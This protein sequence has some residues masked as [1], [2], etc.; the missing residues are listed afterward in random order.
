MNS[1]MLCEKEFDGDGSLCHDCM[2]VVRW[3]ACE[4]CGREFTTVETD[5]NAV[6]DSCIFCG[7]NAEQEK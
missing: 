6:L 7:R 2:G 3:V 5:Y 4:N 1:C